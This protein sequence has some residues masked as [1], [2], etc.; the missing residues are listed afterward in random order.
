MTVPLRTSNVLARKQP[1]LQRYQVGN[2]LK[3]G[4]IAGNIETWV[5]AAIE[6]KINWGE[7]IGKLFLDGECAVMVI[8][9]LADWQHSPTS[10]TRSRPTSRPAR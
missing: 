9:S 1:R 8:P 10:W 6:K 3:A 4:L 5:N 7:L 2:S